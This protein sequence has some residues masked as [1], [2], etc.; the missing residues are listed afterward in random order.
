LPAVDVTGTG[1]SLGAST[2]MSVGA[3]ALRAQG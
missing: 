3:R 1:M 2:E